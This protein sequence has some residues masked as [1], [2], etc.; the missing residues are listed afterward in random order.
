MCGL[1]D[2]VYL[3]EFATITT[4]YRSCSL[5]KKKLHIHLPSHPSPLPLS[6]VTTNLSVSIELPILHISHTLNHTIWL[7]S[8]TLMFPVFIHVK[9]YIETTFFFRL[10]NT[11][12]YGCTTFSISVHQM[13]ETHD[14]TQFCF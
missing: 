6:L 12:L 5:L 10:N 11:P 13:M 1:V 4:N 8:L 14:F 7:L 3:P 9:V 2:L